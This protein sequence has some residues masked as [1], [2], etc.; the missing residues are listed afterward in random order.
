MASNKEYLDYVLEQLSELNEITYKSMMGN[1]LSI[2]KAKSW[3][4]YMTIVFL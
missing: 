3:V 4:V 1:L 2:I